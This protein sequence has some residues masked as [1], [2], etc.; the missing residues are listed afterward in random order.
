[1]L[2]LTSADMLSTQTERM[3][4]MVFA[5]YLIAFLAAS[6]Q[7]LSDSAI[8]SITLATLFMAPPEDLSGLK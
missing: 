1:M 2:S 7:L 6:S 5:A 4:L 8:S 3:F